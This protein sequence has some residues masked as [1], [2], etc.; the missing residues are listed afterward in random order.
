MAAPYS[1]EENFPIKIVPVVEVNFGSWIQ[2]VNE[3]GAP[4]I[5]AEEMIVN[6]C[7]SD[8]PG[9]FLPDRSFHQSGQT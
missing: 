7:L 5:G 2:P 1:F 4:A 8:E 9:C 6:A 3:I